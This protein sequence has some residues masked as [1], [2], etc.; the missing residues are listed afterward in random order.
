MTSYPESFGMTF[1]KKDHA[2]DYSG[3]ITEDRWRQIFSVRRKVM[4]AVNLPIAS[5]KDVYEV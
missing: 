4:Q 1:I 2:R 3:R 5:W